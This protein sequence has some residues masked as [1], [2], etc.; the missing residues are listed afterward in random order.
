MVSGIPKSAFL[1]YWQ[2]PAMADA[3]ERDGG[4][5]YITL[6]VAAIYTS[7]VPVDTYTNQV[8]FSTPSNCT[9][10][11]HILTLSPTVDPYPA[12]PDFNNHIFNHFLLHFPS[13]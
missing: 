10:Q 1:K 5:Q 11:A 4:A 12:I 2:W 13:V 7:P 9:L 6:L 3:R 8:C